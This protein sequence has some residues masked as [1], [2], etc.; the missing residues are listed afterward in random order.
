M[1]FEWSLPT[2]IIFGPGRF[3]STHKFV[4][5]LGKRAFVVTSRSYLNGGTRHAVLADLLSQLSSIGV[6]TQIF[7]EIEPNPRTT[8][9]DR[10]AALLREFR[11]R[12]VIALGG[13]SVMDAAKCLALLGVNDGGVYQYAYRGVGQSMTPFN[14][15]LP[16]VC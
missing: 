3:H 13:G 8:T 2:R 10:A 1:Q 11:P 4:R 6:E 7:G 14:H 12:Y 16:L 5:G 9:V 15:A